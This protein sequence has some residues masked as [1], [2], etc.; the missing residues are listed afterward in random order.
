MFLIEPYHFFKCTAEINNASG[1][2][3]LGVE[4][5]DSDA[6]A[7]NHLE[8]TLNVLKNVHEAFY[9][10]HE[11]GMTGTSAE[12]QMAG[13]GRDVKAILNQVSVVVWTF[14]SCQSGN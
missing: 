2:G 11:G 13:R 6:Q 4:A 8:H 5:E 10:G 12:D 7:D 3:V 1:N 9:E 14:L